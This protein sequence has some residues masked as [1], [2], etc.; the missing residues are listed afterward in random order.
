M[1]ING[2]NRPGIALALIAV[3]LC[4]CV[5]ASGP[6]QAGVLD[7]VIGKSAGKAA[8]GPKDILKGATDKALDRVSQPDG[9]LKD[10]LIRIAL[11][12][13]LKQVSKAM[14]LGSRL[15]LTKDMDM[16][17]NRAAEKAAGEAK[18]LFRAAVDDMSVKDGV[19]I[20]TGGSD[21]ATQYF[22]KTSGEAVEDKMRPLIASALA[23][24]GALKQLGKL[25]VPGYSSA[26]LTDYVTEKA[27]DGIFHYI[28][29]EE[30]DLRK[31]PEKLL[32][33]LIK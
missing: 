20:A 1:A 6:A 2:G 31:N 14:S 17:I 32:K 8:A 24:T 28:A 33:A 9:F 15:G 21:G 19:D 16:L 11:P 25:R 29:K 12:G 23:D 22:R 7:K 10:E 18:P 26:D 27:T 3:A 30:A 5:A 4:G 13:P